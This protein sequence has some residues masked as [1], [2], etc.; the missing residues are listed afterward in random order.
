MVSTIGTRALLERLEQL[1]EGQAAAAVAFDGDGTLWSGDVGEDVFHH[2]MRHRLLREEALPALRAAAKQ[3]DV[4]CEGDANDV[5]QRIFDAYVAGK[6][7]EREVCA[8]MTWCYAGMPATEFEEHCRAVLTQHRISERLHGELDPIFVFA[9]KKGVRVVV[10]SAS[11]RAMVEIAAQHWG[12]APG[13]VAASTPEVN[14]GIIAA[15]NANEVPYAEAKVGAARSLFGDSLWLASFGDNV[16]DVEMFQAA[17]IG[18]AVRPKHALRTR[19]PE[20]TSV[21]VLEPE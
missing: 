11:P 18:V 2:A 14:G 1:C 9:R 8:V 5:A 6:Y 21:L 17:R 4:P 20:L 19:L 15:K 13:D 16:F 7:P 12:I 10:V 3:H